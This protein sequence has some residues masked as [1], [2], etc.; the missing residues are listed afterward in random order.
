M[1]LRSLN[2]RPAVIETTTSIA[3]IV[4]GLAAR[5]EACEK[6]EGRSDFPNQGQ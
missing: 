1:K 5:V 3:A 2:I 6:R 4:A